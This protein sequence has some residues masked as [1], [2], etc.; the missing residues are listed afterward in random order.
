M[1]HTPPHPGE[2]IVEDYL[3]PLGLS[4]TRAASALGVSRKALS[5]LVNGKSGI[6]ADMAVRLEKVFGTEAGFWVRLQSQYDLW[7]A[8]QRMRKWRPKTTF[9]LDQMTL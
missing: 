8:M 5:E 4:V 9:S 6:S 2:H 1:M 3:I 7:H